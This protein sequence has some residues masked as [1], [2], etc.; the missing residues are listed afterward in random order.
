MLKTMTLSG[1]KEGFITCPATLDDVPAIT[2]LLNAC[3]V[4]TIGVADFTVES[5]R[6]DFQAP[7]LDLEKDTLLVFAP[8]GKLVGYADVFALAQVPV[9][10]FV[11]GR[12]HPEHE[13][14]GIGTAML[15][16]GDAR[17]HH[18]FDRVPADARIAFRSNT[19]SVNEAAKR[20]LEGYGM[21]LAR[22]FLTMRIDLEDEPQAAQ[23]PQG[24]TVRTMDT[25]KDLEAVYRSVD[26]SFSDHFGHQEEDFETGFA[27][28]KHFRLG[29]QFFDPSLWLLAV[30]GDEIAG[31][32]LC[33]IQSYQEP[34]MGWVDTLGV[35]RG[36]RK[37]GLGLALLQHSFVE[38]HKRGKPSVGLGVDA[39]N[40]TGAL[41]LYERAGMSVY[42][43]YDMY[44]KELRPGIELSKV[45]LDE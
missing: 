31:F 28:F 45:Q 32:S 44:E 9:H 11:F 16:W 19:V 4:A 36:W 15:E 30:E 34:E 41:R 37:R 38:L 39:Y 20:L 6:N 26:E 5:L 43:Q 23:W 8:E 10:P 17:A 1:L 42:R 35:R 22:H 2:D 3:S 40:L 25:E 13:N 12:V 33:R 7:G 18:V 21:Q 14:Q 29:D 24:I 27:R